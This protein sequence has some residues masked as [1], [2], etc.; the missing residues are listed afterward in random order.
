MANGFFGRESEIAEVRG[1]GTGL[2]DFARL[3]GWS[4]ALQ[5]Y[6]SGM[7]SAYECVE[8]AEFLMETAVRSALQ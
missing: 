3:G 5:G 7:A 6:C 4:C 1:C 2:R 8:G